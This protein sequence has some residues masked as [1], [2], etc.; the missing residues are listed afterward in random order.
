MAYQW[1]AIHKKQGF[2]MSAGQGAQAVA[3]TGGQDNAFTYFSV[4]HYDAHPLRNVTR[5]AL[6]VK[7]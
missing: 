3:V 2:G 6:H 5:V 4:E 1:D 7:P